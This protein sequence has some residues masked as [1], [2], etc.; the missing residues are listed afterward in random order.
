[1]W[2]IGFIGIVFLAAIIAEL[3]EKYDKKERFARTIERI[4]KI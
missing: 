2:I 3:I 4:F 1:M